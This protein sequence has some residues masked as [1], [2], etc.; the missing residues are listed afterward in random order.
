MV[1]YLLSPRC[2]QSQLVLCCGFSSRFIHAMLSFLSSSQGQVSSLASHYCCGSDSRHPQV[3]H[4]VLVPF[5][6]P[7]HCFCWPHVYLSKI[8]WWFLC[9]GLK[10]VLILSFSCY[11]FIYARCI[12]WQNTDPSPVSVSQGATILSSQGPSKRRR[13]HRCQQQF[14][15]LFP[16]LPLYPC[17]LWSMGLV[18]LDPTDPR[19]LDPLVSPALPQ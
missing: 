9:G 19:Q 6:P 18:L 17:L 12:I 1:W 14:C 13:C 10:I 5:F 15:W 8:F 7:V 2:L 11:C 4:S 3:S 16:V